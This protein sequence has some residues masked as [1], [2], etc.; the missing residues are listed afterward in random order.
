MIFHS[1]VSSTQ[2]VSWRSTYFINVHTNFIR[3]PWN[4]KILQ[5][6]FIQIHQPIQQSSNFQP[7]STTSPGNACSTHGSRTTPSPSEATQPAAGRPRRSRA[8][9]RPR[10]RGHLGGPTEG[11]SQGE[12]W[13]H[14][15]T[16]QKMLFLH[17]EET[18]K[19]WNVFQMFSLWWFIGNADFS[20]KNVLGI[21]IH[22]PK[23]HPWKCQMPPVDHW[24][25]PQE[26]DI[27]C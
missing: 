22:N 4:G 15:K 26:S 9:G 20:G 11:V 19:R 2:R 1:Y 27:N 10:P 7:A 24:W 23:V 18:A 25:L 3:F 5:P 17:R 8:P 16:V 21:T 13:N 12:D 14:P 6:F